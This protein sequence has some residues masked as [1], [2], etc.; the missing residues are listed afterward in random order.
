MQSEHKQHGKL[1]W[2]HFIYS[3]NNNSIQQRGESWYEQS[4]EICGV[5]RKVIG[6]KSLSYMNNPEIL[7]VCLM[8]KWGNL[9]ENK[10]RRWGGG[11]VINSIRMTIN[12]CGV[13]WKG[14]FLFWVGSQK[15]VMRWR[16][17]QVPRGPFFIL[18]HLFSSS[19]LILSNS[20]AVDVIALL[21]LLSSSWSSESTLAWQY[22]PH[23]THPPIL[24]SVSIYFYFTFT[25]KPHNLLCSPLAR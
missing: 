9:Q 18:F 21:L 4:Y 22:A 17:W 12:V 7:D 11:S 16:R 25:Q 19:F 23:I 8:Q 2:N 5:Q 14:N 15:L 10:E 20:I 6:P 3:R 24:F 1:H 13:W